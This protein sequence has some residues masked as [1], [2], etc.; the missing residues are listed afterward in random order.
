MMMSPNWFMCS[1]CCLILDGRRGGGIGFA[2]VLTALI[3][4]ACAGATSYAAA[5]Q[6][7]ADLPRSVLSRV[8]IGPGTPAISTL[9][10]LVL[11]ADADLLGKR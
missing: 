10:R 4:A 11:A 1:R 7:I 6:W 3:A 9:R 2:A 8:G 5:A